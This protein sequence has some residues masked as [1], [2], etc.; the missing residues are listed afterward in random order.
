M[1]ENREG[2]NTE[3][4]GMLTGNERRMEEV[5]SSDNP[6]WWESQWV[7]VVVGMVT[8]LFMISVSKRSFHITDF[9]WL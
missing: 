9:E 6:P 8:V 7:V 2:V 1:K 3:T 5:L 4:G